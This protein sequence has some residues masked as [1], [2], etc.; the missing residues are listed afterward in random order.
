[1]RSVLFQ[2]Y[3]VGA[4]STLDKACC[5]GLQKWESLADAHESLQ[6]FVEKRLIG[7]L[8]SV[9]HLRVILG[10]R[11]GENELVEHLIPLRTKVL[12]RENLDEVRENLE[13]EYILVKRLS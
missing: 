11:E 9:A 12:E 1:M 7:D 6:Q 3:G 13:M 5:L 8:K 2:L 10:L 4:E